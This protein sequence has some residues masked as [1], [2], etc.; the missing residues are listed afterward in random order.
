MPRLAIFP[1]GTTCNGRGLLKFSKGAF[2]DLKPVKILAF[3]FHDKNKYSFH[4][5]NISAGV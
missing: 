3:K 2:M 1:E 5:D 4:D